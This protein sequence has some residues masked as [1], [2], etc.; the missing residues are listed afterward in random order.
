MG[1][2]E[3]PE[4]SPSDHAK[5]ELLDLGDAGFRIF[6][7]SDLDWTHDPWLVAKD[8]GTVWTLEGGM[9][10]SGYRP[11]TN[12]VLVG[13]NNSWAYLTTTAASGFRDAP[14]D[15]AE[16]ERRARERDEQAKRQAAEAERKLA[17]LR[18]AAQP[19]TTGDVDPAL[20]FTLAQAAERIARA[21]GKVELTRR[22]AHRE[23]GAGRRKG[24]GHR[25]ARRGA[26]SLPRRARRRGAVGEGQSSTGCG[27][28]TGGRRHRIVTRRPNLAAAPRLWL[29]GDA[30][31]DKRRR[32]I[33]RR[34]FAG[35]TEPLPPRDRVLA[36]LRHRRNVVDDAL[37]LERAL[38]WRRTRDPAR[39]RRTSPPADRQGSQTL[40]G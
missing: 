20:R 23:L 40:A 4:V 35:S 33:W 15:L 39:H 2:V 12:A 21:G 19:V 5:M 16:L 25:A 6:R 1:P 17:A 31:E 37:A 18:A 30:A 24:M 22:A 29:T 26:R 10:L 8:D 9:P 32:T 7:P 28:H 14:R 11:N 34:T 36:E 38:Q 27:R 3:V 13:K